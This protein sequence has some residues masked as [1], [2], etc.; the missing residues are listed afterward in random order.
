MMTPAKVTVLALVTAAAVAAAVVTVQNSQATRSQADRGKS[1]LPGFAGQINDVDRIVIRDGEAVTEIS[2]SDGRYVDRSG[3]PV[4]VEAVSGLL[5]GLSMLT[6]EERKTDQP[7]RF[8]D[9]ELAA[10]DAEDGAGQQ[11]TVQAGE[12]RLADVIIGSRDA[13]VGGTRGGMFV[14]RADSPP[15][16]LLRGAVALPG[17]RSGWFDTALYQLGTDKLLTAEFKP[18]E[19]QGIRLSQSA[20]SK[21]IVLDNLPAGRTAD[22][23]KVQRVATLAAGMS[24]EDVR[25]A[26]G[27][28]SGIQLTAVGSNQR[29]YQ[30]TPVG[31]FDPDNTWVQIRIAA[32]SVKDV[33]AAKKEN[34]PFD[35]FE[36]KLSSYNAEPLAWTLT[37]LLNKPDA[38]GT[39]PTATP[40]V[41]GLPAIP[42]LPGAPA[43]PGSSQ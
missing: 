18:K 25:K 11:V 17:S 40:P 8:A 20:S 9:L 10:P 24:F 30:I 32:E 43:A 13:T 36:F 26:Q 21:T 35:G 2:R 22:P 7:A 31:E 41:P 3:Y 38:A 5:T 19:G 12:S 42:G 39:A 27:E 37:D 23:A 33:A 6:I 28:P 4:R 15:A 29:R 16:Y 14:R 34:E 1:F